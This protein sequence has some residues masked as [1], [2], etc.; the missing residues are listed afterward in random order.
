MFDFTDPCDLMLSTITEQADGE[1][2]RVHQMFDLKTFHALRDSVKENR[3][4]VLFTLTILEALNNVWVPPW[5]WHQIAKVTLSGGLYLQW[6]TAF[7]DFAQETTS[8]N[9]Q[10]NVAITFEMLTG[11]GAFSTLQAQLT[12]NPQA[13]E[14]FSLCVCS[15]WQTLSEPGKPNK[16]F[17]KCFQRPSEAFADFLDCLTKAVH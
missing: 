8:L 16:S 15:A 9:A 12:Y 7:G 3:V 5:D 13:Y 14:L 11:T 6:K 17:L 4:Q 1:I 10:N 2:Q